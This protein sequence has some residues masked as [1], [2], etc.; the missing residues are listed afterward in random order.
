MQLYQRTINTLTQQPLIGLL[1]NRNVLPKYGF[2]PTR[3]SCG[4]RTRATRG[5]ELELSRDLSSAIYEYAPGAEVV[6]G[7]RLWTSR[8]VY[9]L[10]KRELLGNYYAVCARVLAVP[11]GRH[12]G[13]TGA[14]VPVVWNCAEGRAAKLPD[15]AVRIRG[16]A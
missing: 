8:G 11:G 3:L 12:R 16:V 2:P 10:P 1:A 9:R 14:C 13:G 15:A 7:G 6:A 5:P 4:P